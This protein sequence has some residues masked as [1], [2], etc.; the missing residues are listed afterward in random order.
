VLEE[1]FGS[2]LASDIEAYGYGEVADYLTAALPPVDFSITNPPF[3]SAI[4]FVRKALANAR[5]GVAMFLPTR[6][7]EGI[8]RYQ[9]LFAETPPTLVA[10]FCERVPLHKDTLLRKNKTQ[11]AYSWYI[12]LKSVPPTSGARLVWIPPCRA[13]LER[14]GYYDD[15]IG[16]EPMILR[17]RGHA[18]PDL[19]ALA[20]PLVSPLPSSTTRLAKVGGSQ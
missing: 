11:T 17:P 5:M 13:W 15:D 3:H 8:G 14:W 10:Q 4:A 19:A 12:W 2:V 18:E 9:T 6:W 7:Q 16:P 20:T 1:Y